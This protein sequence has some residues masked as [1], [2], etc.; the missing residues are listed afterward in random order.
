MLTCMW[1]LIVLAGGNGVRPGV[2]L[3]DNAD[4]LAR[5]ERAGEP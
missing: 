2:D 5:M 4:L 1:R 3:D